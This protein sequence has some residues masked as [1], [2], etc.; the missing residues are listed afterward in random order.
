MSQKEFATQPHERDPL[1]NLA[2]TLKTAKQ[3]TQE[4][5]LKKFYSFI[6]SY[7]SLSD[8]VVGIQNKR[9]VGLLSYATLR[10]YKSCVLYGL[11][12]LLACHRH[13]PLP[14]FFSDEQKG[15]LFS[16]ASTV[17]PDTL[18]EL[19]AQAYEWKAEMVVQRQLLD[20]IS[21]SVNASS[22]RRAKSF[23]PDLVQRIEQIE[24]NSFRFLKVFIELNTILGLRPHEYYHSQ[25]IEDAQFVKDKIPAESQD[26]FELYQATSHPCRFWLQVLN[27]KYSDDPDNPL[28]RA[29]GEYRYIGLDGLGADMVKRIHQ[30]CTN[31]RKRYATEDDF[32]DFLDKEQ[33]RLSRFLKNDAICHQIVMTEHKKRLKAY[34]RNQQSGRAMQEGHI[35]VD[36]VAKGASLLKPQ[37]PTLYSTRHQAIANAKATGINDIMIAS[38]FGHIS[39]VT[40]R[41]HYGKKQYGNTSCRLV[42]SVENLMMVINHVHEQKLSHERKKQLEQGRNL[43]KTLLDDYER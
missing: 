29:C 38:L 32:K 12:L 3:S 30:F 6:G 20:G 17:S 37:Y 39:P 9:E 18:D 21:M 40:N 1:L 33:R 2:R 7:G 22:N 24:R 13:A 28:K 36:M 11:G 43:H 31:I 5:Y 19:Y 35:A 10:L 34:H 25:V 41:K 27:S 8:A 4:N 26:L 42:P 16:L 15:R 14:E 23:Y